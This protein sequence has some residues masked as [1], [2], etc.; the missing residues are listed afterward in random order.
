[1]TI[2]IASPDFCVSSSS[3]DELKRCKTFKARLIGPGIDAVRKFALIELDDDPLIADCITGTIYRH[4]GLHHTS[5]RVFVTDFPMV[6]ARDVPKW[7]SIDKAKRSD[8]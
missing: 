1:M 3:I 7:L 4:D 5:S 6:A 2:R 8:Q